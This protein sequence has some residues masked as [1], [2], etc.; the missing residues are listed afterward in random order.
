MALIPRVEQ[1]PRLT[2]RR[3]S[4]MGS[5]LWVGVPRRVS[6]ASAILLK[7]SWLNSSPTY[8]FI[9]AYFFS[10]P[11]YYPRTSLALPP[12]SNSDS[13][14]HCGP[15]FRLPTTVR[16]FIFIARKNSSFSSLFDS[17]RIVR[18]Y[19]PAATSRQPESSLG[20]GVDICEPKKGIPSFRLSS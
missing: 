1:I 12:S 20:T 4:T 11:I 16:A 13:G 19:E 8:I 6:S 10:H 17:R 7:L 18:C 3:V 2:K 5:V 14:S 9:L 15:S